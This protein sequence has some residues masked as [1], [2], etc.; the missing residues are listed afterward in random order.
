M[1]L[2]PSLLVSA[3]AGMLKGVRGEM[4][5][6]VLGVSWCLVCV[7]G[8]YSCRQHGSAYPEMNEEVPVKKHW[9]S[10]AQPISKAEPNLSPSQGLET[11][12][13]PCLPWLCLS[14]LSASMTSG[15]LKCHKQDS[16]SCN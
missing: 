13:N 7:L 11:F 10:P 3:G 9:G 12:R 2:G 8:V 1:S 4:A 14:V 5:E 16:S 6:V 15:V